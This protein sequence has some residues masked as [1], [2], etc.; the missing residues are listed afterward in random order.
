MF[1]HH[2]SMFY[3]VADIGATRYDLSYRIGADRILTA[4]VLQ[5]NPQVARMHR[6]ICRFERGGLSQSSDP[7]VLAQAHEERVR[8][9]REV[10]NVPGP[11][12]WFLMTVKETVEAVRR[13]Y[14]GLYDRLRMRRT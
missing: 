10:F 7:K 12:A 11:L 13:R 8:A 3:R 1:A 5:T 9:L 14:P 6:A 4:R 2:Q